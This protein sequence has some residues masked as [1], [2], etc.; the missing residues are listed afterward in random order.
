M[1]KILIIILFSFTLFSCD[2][3]Q[4][5]VQQKV[6]EEV[7]KTIQEQLN[8]LDSSLKGI[9][10][11]SIKNWNGMDSVAVKLDSASKM[12]DMLIKEQEK[13]INEQQEKLNNSKK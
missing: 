6:D 9:N 12:L 1:N 4:E 7:N 5:K 11:D 10:I 8:Q 13:K 3:I 2:S